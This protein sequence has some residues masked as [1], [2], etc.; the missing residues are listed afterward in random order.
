MKKLILILITIFSIANLSAQENM[1]T[2]KLPYYEVPE[3]Y[4]EY[5]VGTVT[6][7]MIDGLGFRYRWAT[8]D[9][10]EE[11]L[12]YK[13]SE[14][15]RTTEETINHILGLSWVIVNSVT[16]TPTD[17]TKE[18]PELT[19]AEKRK[20]TLLNFQKASMIL[21]K[22]ESLDDF[23]I[24]FISKNGT[25]EYPFWNQL[26]GPIADALWHCG[27]VVLLRRA[28]GN[29]LREGVSFLNGKVRD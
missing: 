7:R 9:L 5:T 28:S 10:R 27:Q 17:F 20:Q 12:K 23:K 11:D 22:T 29:P 6:A 24:E 18:R 1:K 2:E 13:P 21:Q 26:N 15:G 8:E 14:E 19:F 16:K 3:Y 25:N 4:S